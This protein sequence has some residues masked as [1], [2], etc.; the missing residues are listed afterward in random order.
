MEKHQLNLCKYSQFVKH[1]ALFSALFCFVAF[2]PHSY[3]LEHA[4]LHASKQF[5]WIHLIASQEQKTFRIQLKWPDANEHQMHFIC[6]AID[7]QNICMKIS[8][9]S[10]H[11]HIYQMQTLAIAQQFTV[12]RNIYLLFGKQTTCLQFDR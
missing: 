1:S 11:H 7:W 3:T 8:V 5:L 6:S 4:L 9:G 12:Y 10:T 2:F